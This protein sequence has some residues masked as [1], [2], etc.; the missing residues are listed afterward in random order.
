MVSILMNYNA[1]LDLYDSEL[2]EEAFGRVGHL[3]SWIASYTL[4]NLALLCGESFFLE[5]ILHMLGGERF[6]R[7]YLMSVIFPR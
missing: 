4:R 7:W 2:N 1:I 3:A 5:K 6:V